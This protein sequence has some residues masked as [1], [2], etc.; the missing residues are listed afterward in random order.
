MA[1]PVPPGVDDAKVEE[2]LGELDGLLDQ[3]ESMTGPDGDAARAAVTSLAVV[4]GEALGRALGAAGP[5]VARHLASDALVGHLMALHGLHPDPT[6]DRV[7]GAIEAM[8][9]ELRQREAVQLEEL[10]DGQA[11]VRVAGS[12][13][14][15]D[16]LAASVHDILL[17]V[18][19]ELT[20]VEAIAVSPA[21]EAPTSAFIPLGALRHRRRP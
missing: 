19:P 18:A 20:G 13:C 17:G 11:R 7:A 4:Y 16:G 8:Q 15:G 1:D 3:V 5:E 14:G 9:R 6:E 10:S 21:P 2:H 12:G